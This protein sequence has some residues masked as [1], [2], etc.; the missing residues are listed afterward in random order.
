[1]LL[2]SENITVMACNSSSELIRFILRF[3]FIDYQE[4]MIEK[5]IKITLNHGGLHIY[6]ISKQMF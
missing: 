4:N 3:P 2:R 1:M 5:I 6:S